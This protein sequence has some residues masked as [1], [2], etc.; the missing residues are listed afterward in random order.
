MNDV[1]HITTTRENEDGSTDELQ[2][3][4]FVRGEVEEKE[5]DGLRDVIDLLDDANNSGVQWKAV[6]RTVRIGSIT[7]TERIER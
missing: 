6:Q 2:D 4:D 7:I 3:A 1:Y 5:G